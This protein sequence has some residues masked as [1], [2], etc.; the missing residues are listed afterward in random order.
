MNLAQFYGIL[1]HVA[2]TAG[3]VLLVSP[4]PRFQVAGVILTAL[5]TGSSYVSKRPGKIRPIN[6]PPVHLLV[7]GLSLCAL[8]GA[9]GCAGPAAT[10]GA[11]KAEV[12]AAITQPVTKNLVVPLLLKNPQLEPALQALAS[13]IEL[14]FNK[15]TLTPAE[16][17]YFLDALAIEYPQLDDRDK[18]VIG[19]A[20][21]DAYTIYTELSGK[22]VVDVTDPDARQL[23]EA[24]RR[25]VLDGIAFYHAFK[26]PHASQHFYRKNDDAGGAHAIAGAGSVC[27][28][29]TIAAEH[30]EARTCVSLAS[31]PLTERLAI[32]FR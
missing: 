20:V 23:L 27:P 18:L 22:A 15:S 26:P 3:G 32:A 28:V 6:V 19:S 30:E 9:V 1:R 14:V 12:T 24:F 31:A 4:D 16:I 7:I 25:G 5:G 11:T 21:M 10:G 13:G 17:K 8:L 29:F 2:T